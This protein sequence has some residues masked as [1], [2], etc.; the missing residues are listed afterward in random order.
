[1]GA[2]YY[3][4][5]PM[6]RRRRLGLTAGCT[7]EALC[8]EGIEDV[9]HAHLVEAKK[10]RT[11]P[12]APGATQTVNRHRYGALAD[13]ATKLHAFQMMHMDAEPDQSAYDDY[14]AILKGLQHEMEIILVADA[15]EYGNHRRLT[16]SSR[17]S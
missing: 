2:D 16:H 7:Q 3:C 11:H 13:I 8:E 1:M 14:N 15:S 9:V 12:S 6:W 10:Q 4:H 17:S 5:S